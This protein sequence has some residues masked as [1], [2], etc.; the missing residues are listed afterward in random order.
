LRAGVIDLAHGR[1]HDDVGESAA[2]EFHVCHPA[3]SAL[4]G[5]SPAAI[6]RARAEVS[7]GK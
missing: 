4:L 3:G 2:G 1:G 5:G 6:I 7:F